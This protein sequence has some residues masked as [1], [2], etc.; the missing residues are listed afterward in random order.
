MARRLMPCAVVA[1]VVMAISCGGVSW[2][3]FGYDEPR[4]TAKQKTQ[5]D[6]SREVP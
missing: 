5:Q 4:R 2:I 3:R 1:I 6:E